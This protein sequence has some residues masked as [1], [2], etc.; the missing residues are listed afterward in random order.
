MKTYKVCNDS[1]EDPS[2]SNQFYPNYDPKDHDFYFI[3][4][5][6]RSNCRVSE[7]LKIKLIFYLNPVDFR[8]FWIK[9]EKNKFNLINKVY[10]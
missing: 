9:I 7:W 1:G 6:S 2:C 10:I 5:D 8:N 3:Q 4:I